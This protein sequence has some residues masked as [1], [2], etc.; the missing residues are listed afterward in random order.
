[1]VGEVGWKSPLGNPKYA[2]EF[3]EIFIQN[4]NEKFHE[5]LTTR[6]TVFQVTYFQCNRRHF[7]HSPLT[8]YV[9]HLQHS[10]QPPERSV[11]SHAASAWLGRYHRADD[12]QRL[13]EVIRRHIRSGVCSATS[14][15]V[16][17]GGRPFV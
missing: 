4:F 9:A 7:W 3:S 12:H 11:L 2:T 17:G 10:Q 8:V 14:Q 5:L 13:E 16:G 1:M 15:L 6:V